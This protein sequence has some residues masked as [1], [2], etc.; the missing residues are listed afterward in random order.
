MF[1]PSAA[2][3]AARTGDINRDPVVRGEELDGR[4]ADQRS[5]RSRGSRGLPSVLEP[6]SRERLTQPPQGSNAVVRSRLRRLLPPTQDPQRPERSL[7]GPSQRKKTEGR[8]S[9]SLV[10]NPP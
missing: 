7:G 6:L 8:P 4:F 1:S 9:T 3:K 10:L 5:G 2:E